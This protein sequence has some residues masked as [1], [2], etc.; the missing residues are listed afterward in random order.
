MNPTRSGL[1]V[2]SLS[3]VLGAMLL[4]PGLHAHHEAIFGPQSSTLIS[5]K[6]F[7]STQYY[8]I[9]EGRSPEP[10]GSSHIGV[11]S[12]GFP[13]G[14][15][16]S[17]VTTLP[18]E[19]ERESPG[20]SSTGVQD[21]VLGI[22][23]S[24]DVG[25]DRSLMW[26]LTVEPPT[27]SLEHRAVGVGGGMLYGI[28]WGRWSVVAY[29]L[30]RTESSLEHGEKRGDRLFLGGGLSYEGS[31]LPFSPQL[32]ISWEKTGRAREAGVLLSDS[33]TSALMIHP[34]VSK[35]MTDS[36]QTFFV[37]SVPIAQRSGSEGWQR[38]RVAVGLLWGF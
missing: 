23:H 6:R 5:R 34:T 30:G 27:G 31:S 12:V 18:I 2:A 8:Y 10:L 20:E 3:A 24:P 7:V 29:G 33:R 9:R 37:V 22:R 32:G 35:E 28:E 36:L 16:W 1:R 21:L 13:V 17:M 19:A 15:R 26:L 25:G 14:N 4:L 38:T 11:V